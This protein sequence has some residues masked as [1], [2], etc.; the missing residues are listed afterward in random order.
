[1]SREEILCTRFGE[2]IDMISC[3]AVFKGFAKE[4]HRITDFDEAMQV[5]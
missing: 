2:M 5:R 1:M 3:Y 4:T